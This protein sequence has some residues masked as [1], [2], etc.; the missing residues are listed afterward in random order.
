M[1]KIYY[2]YDEVKGEME[3]RNRNYKIWGKGWYIRRHFRRDWYGEIISY[4]FTLHRH[5]KRYFDNI[6]RIKNEI[7]R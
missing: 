2:N 1:G 7:S 3:M 4:K 5:N 6:E